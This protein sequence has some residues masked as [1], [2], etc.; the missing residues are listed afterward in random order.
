MIIEEFSIG[1]DIESIERFRGKSLEKD[2]KF[3]NHIFTPKELEYCFKSK[4]SA[5]HLC[6]RFC[7]KEAIVK[8]LTPLGVEDV[9]YNEIEILNTEKGYPIAIIKKYPDIKVNVSISHNKEYATANAF[10]YKEK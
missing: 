4:N 1:T 7:A 6:G 8:A 9:L 5:Q 3:F 2:L 10:V